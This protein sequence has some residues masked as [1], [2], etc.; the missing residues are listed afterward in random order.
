MAHP[1]TDVTTRFSQHAEEY[2]RTR[3][4][5]PPE[6]L[7][8][9]ADKCGLT[10]EHV[11]A[12]IGSGTG[13][14]ARLFLDNGNP[15]VGVEPNAPMRAAAEVALAEFARFTSL[16][17]RSEATRLPTHAFDLVV[18]GQAF[19]WFEPTATRAEFQRILKPE[20]LVALVWNDRRTDSAFAAGYEAALLAHAPDYANAR[21]RETRDEAAIRAFF[22][23]EVWHARFDNSQRFTWEGLLARVRSASYVPAIESPA[24]TALEAALRALFVAHAVSG[25]VGF[26]YDT[27]VWLG[28][29]AD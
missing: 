22:G 4:G 20:G 12:D 11:I 19:H 18:A 8:W 14:L 29:L 1:A 25:Q 3:P 13:L 10:P 9:L 27:R 5:Y 21:H 2:A 6:L 24:W 26:D 7:D 23:G 28:E 16:D 17:G 15:V